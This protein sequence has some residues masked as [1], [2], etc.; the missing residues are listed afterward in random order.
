M[1]PG[2]IFYS[3]ANI[4]KHIYRYHHHGQS[5][6]VQNS[7]TVCYLL[8]LSDHERPLILPLFSLHRRRNETPGLVS[9]AAHAA[10]VLRCVFK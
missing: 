7:L 4:F 1:T 6:P 9:S 5:F 2:A 8:T 3:V 10:T